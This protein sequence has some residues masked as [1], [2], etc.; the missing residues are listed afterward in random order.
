[1][2]TCHVPATASRVGGKALASASIA[3]LSNNR[4][5]E[6]REKGGSGARIR[7]NMSQQEKVRRESDGVTE[8]WRENSR[9][10]ERKKERQKGDRNREQESK[11]SRGKDGG[12]ERE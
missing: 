1:M 9:K 8:R 10:K 3:R 5:W 12:R 11:I 2:V 4:R 7:K 6:E